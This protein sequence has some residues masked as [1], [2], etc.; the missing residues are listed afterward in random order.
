MVTHTSTCSQ[1]APTLENDIGKLVQSHVDLHELSQEN[2]HR[3]LTTEPDSD[4]S[5]FPRT[6]PS[7]SVPY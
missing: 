3:V 5:F 2:K 7:D 6:R 1:S 4:V